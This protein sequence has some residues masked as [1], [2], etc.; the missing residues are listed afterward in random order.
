M[1]VW[2]Y[3]IA[4]GRLCRPFGGGRIFSAYSG[5]GAYRDQSAHTDKVGQGPLPV[6]VYRAL[7]PRDHPRL[8]PQAIPLEPW[9]GNQMFGRSAFYVHG[10]NRRGDFS[11]S[12]GC[13]IAPRSARDIIA[14]GDIILVIP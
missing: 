7:E 3:Q 14:A 4:A 6:G 5:R 2:T 11:A 13:I 1:N 8:G 12:A 9:G 10:D